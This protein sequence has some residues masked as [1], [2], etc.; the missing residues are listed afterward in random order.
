VLFPENRI[1]DFDQIYFSGSWLRSFEGKG[2]PL[3]YLTGFVTDDKAKNKFDDGVTDKSKNLAGARSYFQYS[4]TPKLQIFNVLGVVLR[5]DKDAFARSTTVEKG[6]DTFF[7]FALGLTWQFQ[8]KCAVRTQWS[9]T[10]NASNI[11]IYDFNR[12]EVSTAVRCDLF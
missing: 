2:T 11:D 12:N 5:K 10:Q 3:L 1:D 4:Y 7:E 9:Y 8:E 6:K